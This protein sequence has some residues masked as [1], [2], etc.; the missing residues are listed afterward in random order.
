VDV[1]LSEYDYTVEHRPGFKMRHADALS[2]SVNKIEGDL[3]LSKDIIKERQEVD[4]A[5][6]KYK[7]YENFWT[8][9]DG[10]LYR[11]GLKEQPRVV[12]PAAL[13][14]TVLSCYH[15]LQFTAHQGVNRTLNFISK[16]YW[17]ETMRSDVTE[18]IRR[19][20]ACAKRKTGHRLTAPLGEALKASEFLDVVSLD[21]VG[22]LPITEQ[23]NRYLLTF[24][25]HFTRFCEAIPIAKQDTE[26][27]AREFV[28][29]IITQY[30]VPKKFD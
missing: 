13:V 30:G 4:E 10:I 1:K 15:E 25:D 8:D 21:I 24:V 27:I 19:C 3:V 7:Q 29:K 26:A 14:Q 22:P 6:I 2:R 20:E 11:Q 16:K 17:W 12:I 23:G 28:I 18:F 9:E 5:C